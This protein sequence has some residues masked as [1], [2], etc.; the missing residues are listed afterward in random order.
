M[1]FHPHGLGLRGD[2]LFV[3]NHAEGEDRIDVFTLSRDASSGSVAMRFD[4]SHH[5][6]KE[7]LFARSLMGTLNGVC[8]PGNSF[9][10]FLSRTLKCTG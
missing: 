10:I 7:M 9:D 2:R 6:G 4:W 1:A 8:T 3:V 5:G